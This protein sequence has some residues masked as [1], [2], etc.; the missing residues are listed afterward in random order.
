MCTVYTGISACEAQ[1]DIVGQSCDVSTTSKY[2]THT[3]IHVHK[4]IMYQLLC[5][6]ECH[7]HPVHT[8]H[9]TS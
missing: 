9:T 7:I 6:V 3:F 1:K 8:A 2:D 5:S 4:C